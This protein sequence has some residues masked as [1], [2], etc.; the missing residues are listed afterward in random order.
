ML[1]QP[2]QDGRGL[3]VLMG[4]TNIVLRG[5]RPGGDSP[6]V[7]QLCLSLLFTHV[8]LTQLVE[9]GIDLQDMIYGG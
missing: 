6:L 2:C 1:S 3:T 7:T 8:P 4:C 5:R 9:V